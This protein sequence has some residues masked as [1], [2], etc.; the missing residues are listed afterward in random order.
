M[1]DRTC[2]DCPWTGTGYRS[3]A[4]ADAAKSQHS[5]DRAR[6]AAEVTNRH[7]ARIDTSRVERPCLH[8]VAHHQHGTWLCYVGDICRC[9]PCTDAMAAYEANRNRLKAYGKW[10][11]MSPTAPVREHVERLRA[12]GMS[13]KA[14]G[15]T[16]GVGPRVIA[17]LLYTINSGGREIPPSE[18]MRTENAEALLAV[19]F[20]TALE[21]YVAVHGLVRRL[22]ALQAIGYPMAWIAEQGGF[23]T[24]NLNR[25]FK[26]N[27]KVHRST[28]DRIAA[29]YQ[30][31]WHTPA[32]PRRG[33]SAT[34][35][36]KTIEH[37]TRQGWASPLAW[38]ES[39]LDDPDA[40]PDLGEKAHT[41]DVDVIA[42]ERRRLGDKTVLL[43]NADV[44]YLVKGWLRD[45]RSLDD[46]K[47]ATGLRIERMER[48]AQKA[49]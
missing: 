38:D 35:I 3:A 43:S 10:H 39:G 26:G 19:T 36:E 45:G 42:V 23:T 11:P 18:T 15:E 12:Q 6:R 44:Q 5:C 2:P 33:L 41:K 7:R 25:Y 24:G 29:V 17:R 13:I 47:D 31:L 9:R 22:Q 21:G 27:R 49:A 30:G 48:A 20:T 40:V 34:K 4:I 46:L 16:A 14:I 37:A 1:H 32:V 8:T 28:H